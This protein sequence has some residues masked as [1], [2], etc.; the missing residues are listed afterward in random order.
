MTIKSQLMNEFLKNNEEYLVYEKSVTQIDNSEWALAKVGQ[1]KVLMVA[2]NAE[3]LNQLEGRE[4][5]KGLKVSPANHVNRLVLNKLFRFTKPRAFG[6]KVTTMGVG[7]RLGL[8]S[9]GHIQVMRNRQVKPILAQQSIRELN[10]TGRTIYDVLDA[11]AYAAFQEG[12][13]DG[14]GADGDHLKEKEDIKLALDAGMTMLTLDCS[15][16]INN[17]VESY[18]SEEIKET[19]NTLTEVERK[20]YEERYLNKTF[21]LNG[22]SI[23]FS[24]EEVMYNVLLYMD[25]LKYMVSINEEFILPASQEIDFEISID[26]TETVTKPS[27][28]FFVANELINKGVTVNSLAPRFIGE[29]QKGVDYSGDIHSFEK[30]LEVHALIAKY[31]EYKLSI[32]SGSDK[33]S[34][35]PIIAKHTEGLFH[36]KTAGTSWLEAIRV[37]AKHDPELFERMHVYAFEHFPEAQ[38]Y[39]HITPDLNTI[40]PIGVVPVEEY[41]DYM[42]DRNARQVWHVT[43]GVLLTAKNEDGSS[44]FKD[45]F[46]KSLNHL[47]KEYKQSIVKH[48]GKHLDLLSIDEK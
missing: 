43:Y 5:E 17:D 47:E 1:E 42:N 39:Y 2:G 10:L 7:D 30:D 38:A 35:F 13:K 29:F 25:A 8:A 19:Y 22:L 16:H 20:A 34:A 28:H 23:S 12:Y 14:F 41:P 21:D 3:V 6:N 45:D 32:H 15:D 36:L 44:K 46:F 24:K 9:P 4:V 26:E 48:I 27:S 40:K 31:F 33:F 37:L 18:S 11:A